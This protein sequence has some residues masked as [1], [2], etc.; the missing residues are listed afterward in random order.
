MI[1]STRSTQIIKHYN[2]YFEIEISDERLE[3]Y[4]SRNSINQMVERI[5]GSINLIEAYLSYL[6]EYSRTLRYMVKV[7]RFPHQ[8]IPHQNALKKKIWMHR[9]KEIFWIFS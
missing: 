8:K 1:L 2:T 9:A 6:F 4:F 3:M 5:D 7:L